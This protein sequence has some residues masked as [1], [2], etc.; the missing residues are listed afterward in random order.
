[1]QICNNTLEKT[2]CI[3]N[4]VGFLGVKEH[5]ILF[6]VAD[7][8]LSNFVHFLSVLIYFHNLYSFVVGCFKR[9]YD[10]RFIAFSFFQTIGCKRDSR[11]VS[12]CKFVK[13][14][15]EL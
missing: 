10:Y 3:A 15:V 4:Q 1:M 2:N 12:F 9:E 8:A 6:I 7:F 5:I 11:G 14:L 13:N